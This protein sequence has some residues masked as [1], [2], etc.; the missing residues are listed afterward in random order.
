MRTFSQKTRE[1]LAQHSDLLEVWADNQN[2]RP[3]PSGY[4]PARTEIYYGHG[5]APTLVFDHDELIDSSPIEDTM[6]DTF[7]IVADNR[8]VLLQIGPDLLIDISEGLVMPAFELTAFEHELAN[9][10]SRL[11]E[12]AV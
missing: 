6:P 12:V 1:I 10:E 2:N 7:E 4:Q 5:I 3:F 11:Q 9:I 8:L